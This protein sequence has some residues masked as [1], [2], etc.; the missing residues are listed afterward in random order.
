MKTILLVLFAFSLYA[1]SIPVVGS[2]TDLSSNEG[3]G[4]IILNV[5]T[6]SGGIYSYI[7]S[8]Y[9][10]GTYAF[11][12]P[13]SGKQWAKLGAFGNIST[14]SLTATSLTVSGAVNITKSPITLADNVSA[15]VDTFATTA[16]AD[17]VL[18]TGAT[19]TDLYFVTGVG[20]S[21]DQQDVLQVEAKV[22]TLVVH[23]LAAGASGLIYAWIRFSK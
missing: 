19:A 6:S 18:I 20:G 5:P 7:D 1:Q 10:E 3:T 9:A 8:T 2:T 21:V 22:D 15:G 17:T 12:H 11:D 14:A 4:V 16:E 23:R 13:Y